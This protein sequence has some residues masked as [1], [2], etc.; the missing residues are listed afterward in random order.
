MPERQ[1]ANSAAGRRDRQGSGPA[2]ACTA[3]LLD[4]DS[5][6]AQF[7][8]RSPKQEDVV[9]PC[10]SRSAAPAGRGSQQRQQ[11]TTT[12]VV[13]V[14]VVIAVPPRRRRGSRQQHYP[15]QRQQRP[16]RKRGLPRV[17]RQDHLRSRRCRRSSSTTTQPQ[18]EE[19]VGV[20]PGNCP[21]QDLCSRDDVFVLGGG[22]YGRR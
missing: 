22:W 10:P 15:R 5:S 6:Q 14:V 3:A 11:P 4:P 17:H 16:P 18:E 7:D 8:A 2:T 19:V 1:R 13:A 9:H 20:E 21:G 12:N